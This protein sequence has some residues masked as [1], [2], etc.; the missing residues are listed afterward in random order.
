MAKKLRPYHFSVVSNLNET[1]NHTVSYSISGGFEIAPM[2][3]ITHVSL[4]VI[5]KKNGLSTTIW[6]ASKLA[7]TVFISTD[8]AAAASVPSSL[9]LI[10][11]FC[12]TLSIQRRSSS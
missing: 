9:T 4:S 6:K 1:F 8:V 11:D 12:F 3:K 2:N 10:Y 7:D 5:V